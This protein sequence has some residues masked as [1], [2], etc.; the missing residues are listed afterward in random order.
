MSALKAWKAIPA[1]RLILAAELVLLAREHITRLEPAE[2]RRIVELVR[3]GRGWPGR[4]SS[5]ERHELAGLLAKTEPR[6]FA[7]SAAKKLVPF[8]PMKGW[9]WR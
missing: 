3:R 1:A 7:T 4:L 6:L 9:T 5:G 8:R 2:R